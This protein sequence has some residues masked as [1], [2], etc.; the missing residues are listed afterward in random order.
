MLPPK[1]DSRIQIPS[2]SSCCYHPHVIP[3]VTEK[4]KESEQ[5][6]SQMFYHLCLEG[7]Y[8][9]CAHT[10]LVRT[11]QMIPSRNMRG[12]GNTILG[13]WVA[14]SRNNAAL[15]KRSMQLDWFTSCLYLINEQREKFFRC[16]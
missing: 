5:L 12:L 7:T 16:I 6:A 15:W 3:K 10:T 4:E 13:C 9:T 8:T 11:R 2:V 14:A 1:S